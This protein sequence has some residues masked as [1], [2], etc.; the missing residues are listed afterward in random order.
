[1]TSGPHTYSGPGAGSMATLLQFASF[2]AL[3]VALSDGS[4]WRI[5]E[6]QLTTDH[7]TLRLCECPAGVCVVGSQGFCVPRKEPEASVCWLPAD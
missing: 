3:S 5:I 2:L 4:S 6:L 1:M 7:A